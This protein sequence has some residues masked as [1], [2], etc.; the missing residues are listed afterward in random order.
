[1]LLSWP[2]VKEFTTRHIHRHP[3]TKCTYATQTGLYTNVWKKFYVIFYA[4]A[5]IV[6]KLVEL[7]TSKIE[8]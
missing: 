5:L 3:I 8:E 6:N 4:T 7:L 2:R 1:M